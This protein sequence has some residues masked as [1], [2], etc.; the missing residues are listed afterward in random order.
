M[1]NLS[2]LSSKVFFLALTSLR[3]AGKSVSSSVCLVLAII[4]PE[5][6][7]R[8][9]LSSPSL[10][11]AQALRIH[12]SPEV[13][14]VSK[15]EDLV[16][17]AFWV[18]GPSLEGFNDSQELTVVYRV[19]QFRICG[20]HGV[21]SQLIR[22]QNL[23]FLDLF[24]PDFLMFLTFDR[25]S[26]LPPPPSGSSASVDLPTLADEEVDEVVFNIEVSGAAILLKPWMQ[27][28]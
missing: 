22:V 27:R 16:F 15:D 3:K 25:F 14:V 26:I 17:A 24:V 23:A 7:S 13:V 6:V 28:R 18:V 21:G 8:E 9:L 12:E 5:V 20:G 2:I 1:K 4:D 10:S 11:G 19:Y